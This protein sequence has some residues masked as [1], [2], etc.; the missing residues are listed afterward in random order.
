MTLVQVLGTLSLIF[1]A[2]FTYSA[3]YAKPTPGQT[4]RHSII[5]AW[6]GIIIGVSINF[7]MNLIIIPMVT[8]AHLSLSDN[9]FMGWIYT[10]ISIV[11]QYAIRRWANNHLHRLV[12]WLS[13]V[14]DAQ[15]ETP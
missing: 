11:R 5:E 7:F 4:P 15:K 12:N 14:K 6:V 1:V 8:G 2:V 10:L 3:F 13:G 9:W